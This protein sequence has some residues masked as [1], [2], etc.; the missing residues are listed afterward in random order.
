MLKRIRMYFRSTFVR[1]MLSYV[2]IMMLLM[3]CVMG[4]A[5]FYCRKTI[6]QTTETG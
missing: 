4:Y 5:Y 2:L 3:G 6:Y 1:Y